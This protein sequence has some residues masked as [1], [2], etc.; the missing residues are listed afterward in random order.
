MDMQVV[1]LAPLTLSK[2]H[3]DEFYPHDEELYNHDD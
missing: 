2:Y 3:D 1:N